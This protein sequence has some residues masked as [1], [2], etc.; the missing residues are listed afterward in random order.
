MTDSFDPYLLAGG[1]VLRNKLGLTDELALRDAERDLVELRDV[2]LKRSL[3]RGEYDLA[4]LRAFHFALFQDVYDWAG[5][6]RTVNI[7]KERSL[8]CRFDLLEQSSI[9]IFSALTKEP[10]LSRDPSD[11]SQRLGFYLGEINALHP[12]REGNGRAQRAFLWQYALT[13]GWKID[14]SGVSVQE[15]ITASWQAM[16][17]DFEL[18]SRVLLRV[19]S[20][21]V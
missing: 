14:W 10:I 4:H 13:N 16:K 15:N 17:G 8:F 3:L 20:P 6:L 9:E 11:A 19:M 1:N 12:F 18:I 21:V 7:T 5:E 2:H